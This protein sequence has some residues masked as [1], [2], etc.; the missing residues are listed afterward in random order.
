MV[1]VN[2][3]PEQER[4]K[5]PCHECSRRT[6]AVYE[7]GFG[8]EM[9]KFEVVRTRFEMF[10]NPKART[11]TFRTWPYPYTFQPF[12]PKYQSDGFIRCQSSLYVYLVLKI[13]LFSIFLTL[14]SLAVFGK[15]S[16]FTAKI[17]KK[18]QF[19]WI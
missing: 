5:K 19:W 15:K 11:R 9:F 4:H 14:T 8:F 7:P 16:S 10:A 2:S 3:I 6:R 1:L 13:F 17:P 18:D 12:S